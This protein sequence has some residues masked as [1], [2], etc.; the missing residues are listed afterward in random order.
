M[1]TQCQIP[2][3]ATAPEQGR[4]RDD[5]V[6]FQPVP[7]WYRTCGSLLEIV[8]ARRLLVYPIGNLLSPMRLGFFGFGICLPALR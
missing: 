1:N 7:R 8:W 5:E 3:S 2:G 4:R 6:L